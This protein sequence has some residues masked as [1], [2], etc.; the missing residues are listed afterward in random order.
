VSLATRLLSANPGAQVSSALTGVLQTPSAKT[1]T[2][3]VSAGTTWSTKTLPS[4][5]NWW[6]PILGGVNNDTWAVAVGTTIAFSTDLGNTWTS[7]TKNIA[8]GNIAYGAGRWVSVGSTGNTSCVDYSTD[9]IS[10]TTGTMPA[11][12]NWDSIIFAQGRFFA[13][14]YGSNTCATSIDGVTWTGVTMPTQTNARR[15]S[16]SY[17]A[18]IDMWIATSRDASYFDSSPNGTTWTA[19]TASSVADWYGSAGNS[20][21]FVAIANNTTTY[22]TS[23][24]GT[25]WTGRTFAVNT[26]SVMGAE[27]Y[28]GTMVVPAYPP[29]TTVYTSTNGTTWT[30]RTIGSSATWTVSKN[31]TTSTNVMMASSYGTSS[32]AVSLE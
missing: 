31:Q 27:Q 21:I 3:P 30:A 1:A 4:S 28:L 32:I 8:S 23:T 5:G 9:G 22:A 12:N 29:S 19:R 11:P 7:R 10:W 18:T 14:A 16:V 2:V 26:G 17:S 13:I 25:S 20:S 6:A 24:N 15:T